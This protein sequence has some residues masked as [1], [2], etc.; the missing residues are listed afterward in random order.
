MFPTWLAINCTRPWGGVNFRALFTRFQMTCSRRVGSAWTISGSAGTNSSI[1]SSCCSLRTTVWM[2]RNTLIRS[3]ATGCSLSLPVRTRAT[4]SRSSM[5]RAWL[6]T[7][8]QMVLTALAA[9]ASDLV[10]GKRRSSSALSWIR[11]SGCL[12]SWDITAKNS[13]LR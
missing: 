2:S 11:F 9:G 12:S 4:S 13:S 5:M 3:T 6:L 1:V 7:A 10:T 8:S